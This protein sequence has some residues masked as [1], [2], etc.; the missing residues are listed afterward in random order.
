[1][2]VKSIQETN[3][4]QSAWPDHSC[5]LDKELSDRTCKSK[6]KTLRG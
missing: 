5:G 1:M 6:A 2:I 3:V 4:D